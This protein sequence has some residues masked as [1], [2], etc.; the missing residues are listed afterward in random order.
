MDINELFDFTIEEVDGGYDVNLKTK[1]M[2]MAVD[3]DFE[4]LTIR[5]RNV[6]LPK[7]GSRKMID[8]KL[9]KVSKIEVDGD[10]KFSVIDEN[11]H[12]INL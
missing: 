1:D 5:M 7:V 9:T 2:V 11:G 10:A 12:R 4:N 3:G 6:E 8:G